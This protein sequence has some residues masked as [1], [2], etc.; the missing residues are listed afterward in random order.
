MAD[1]DV[2]IQ[3]DRG[4]TIEV[5]QG[6]QG[7]KGDKGDVGPQGP[8]GLPGPAGANGIQG[9]QGP[10]GPQ[11]PQGLTGPTGPQ[12]P[13]GPKGDKGADS[14][15]PG[16]QGPKGDTGD[17]GPAGPQGI[18]GPIGL[19]GP[20]GPQGPQGI[21]GPKGDTG[22]TGPAGPQG[23]QG[24]AGP[25]GDTGDTGPQ[26]PIGLTGPQGIQGPKGDKGDTGDTGPQGMQGPKGDTGDTGPQGPQ[27]VSSNSPALQADLVDD[28]F[29]YW[30]INNP[31]GS[32][33]QTPNGRWEISG[34]GSTQAPNAGS[35]GGTFGACSIN[36][37]FAVGTTQLRSAMSAFMWSSSMSG[38]T[39]FTLSH[40]LRIN[41]YDNGVV[42]R[43]GIMQSPE[44]ANPVG[45]FFEY[46]EAVGA[47]RCRYNNGTNVG[48]Y[49]TAVGRSFNFD[50]FQIEYNATTQTAIFRINGVQ[51]HSTPYVLNSN[52][53]H[54]I[55][56]ITTTSALLGQVYVD[57]IHFV[58][59]VTR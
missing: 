40:R 41:N 16:P 39:G 13:V 14:I 30:Y 53:S 20:A 59:N 44:A 2:V 56:S 38:F 21:Q 35:Y 52:Q 3:E 51:V 27:G 43:F 7:P 47:Y 4:I 57:Y 58:M 49:T 48:T 1:Y 45:L 50:T 55:T 28:M 15:V 10:P 6:L 5:T 12:G 17:T 26:G 9:V 23:I 33:V 54:I 25:K 24:V 18:Q 8:Q 31:G 22:D 29:D 34:P 36:T 11:G 46:N 37:N 42:F 32:F 19:T